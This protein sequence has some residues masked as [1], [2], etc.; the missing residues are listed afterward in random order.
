MAPTDPSSA[1]TTTEHVFALLDAGRYD[2]LRALMPDDVARVLT[3]GAVLGAWADAVAET[4]NLVRCDDTRVELPGGEPAPAAGVL[5]T[6]VGVTTLVCEAG[7]WQG[8]AAL[9]QDGR[10]L[11]ILVVP[12]GAEGLPF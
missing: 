2:D 5:G 6:V 9:G 10:L 3:R 12:V 11:G 1:L 8:R 7:E 4:G